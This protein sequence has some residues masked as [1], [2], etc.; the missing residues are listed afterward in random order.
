MSKPA[1]KKY[2]FRSSSGARVEVSATT[3]QEAR[4]LAMTKLHGPA[5]QF[6]GMPPSLIGKDGWTGSGLSLV[7]REREEKSDAL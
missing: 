3:E 2:V 6:I 1:K 4:E 5:P 7:T